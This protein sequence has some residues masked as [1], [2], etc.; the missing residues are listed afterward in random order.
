MSDDPLLFRTEKGLTVRL[1]DVFLYPPDD[2]HGYARRRALAAEIAPRTL[3]YVP[4]VGLG[5][6]L[7]DLLARLPEESAV[8]C[9]EADQRIMALASAQD[10]PRDSRLTII[11]TESEEAVATVLARMGPGRFRR[12]AQ[13]C[14]SAG[15][16]LSP[17]FYERLRALLSSEIRT[18]WQNRMT[19]IG[20]GS[21]WVRN[22]FENLPLLARSRDF[23]VLTTDRPIVVAGAGPSLEASV[24]LLRGLRPR[25]TLLAVDTALA[26]LA[27][28]S[29][30]PDV[31]VTLE[32]QVQNLAD[33]LPFRDPSI[34]LACELSAHP[35]VARIFAG[36]LFFFASA[37]APLSL[38]DRLEAARLLPTRFPPL[39]SVGVAAVHA[40]LSMTEG[41]V[42]LT[43][44]DLSYPNRLTHS[45]GTPVHLSMLASTHR[46][47][48]IGQDAYNAFV[49]RP[50][51]QAKDKHGLPITTDLVL[52]SYQDQL[53][54]T[55]ARDMD[56]AWDVGVTGMPLG[57]RP[58]SHEEAADRISSRPAG[59]SRP[60]AAEGT[61]FRKQDVDAF[62]EAER[63]LLAKAERR[64]LC[65]LSP[66]ALSQEAAKEEWEI[67]RAVGYS[68]VHFPDEPNPASPGKS[69]LARALVAVRYYRQRLARLLARK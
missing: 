62:L 25:F 41:D 39:G 28:H 29:L 33:F 30:I 3:V 15:Y 42:F 59:A 38:F 43:G 22:L 31:I 69:F 9:V 66:A 37:F 65:E 7:A 5:H 24:P 4:S 21:L 67:L 46:R 36:N 56:R 58:I 6:G 40:A 47:R 34:P 60:A 51:I 14:L 35:P 27:A 17:S 32:A 52:K 11:R 44:L 54:R 57:A 53:H 20:M 8:L 12:V 55:L 23:R 2:P 63:E 45:R 18:Y 61:A 16:R 13:V 10:L 19:L 26:A 1:D 50:L 49:S 64:I 68:Y 48:S